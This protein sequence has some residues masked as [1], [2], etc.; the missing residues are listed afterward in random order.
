MSGNREAVV[1]QWRRSFHVYALL[2][3]GLALVAAVSGLFEG[4]RDRPEALVWAAFMAGI[5]VVSVILWRVAVHWQRRR[6]GS[7]EQN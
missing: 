7:G 5:G 2:C 6:A 4:G 3:F 1:E